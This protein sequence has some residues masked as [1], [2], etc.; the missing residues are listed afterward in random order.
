MTDHGTSAPHTEASLTGCDC[1]SQQLPPALQKHTT[2][3]PSENTP[4]VQ[5]GMTRSNN[6]STSHLAKHNEPYHKKLIWKTTTLPPCKHPHHPS[7]GCDTTCLAPSY[8]RS[9][10]PRQ[11]TVPRQ[12]LLKVHIP[13]TTL[14]L[15]APTLPPHCSTSSSPLHLAPC[16]RIQPA[17]F[18]WWCS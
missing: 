9:L 4:S 6:G 7:R 14:A 10:L 8:E 16:M 11:H 15:A 1:N 12:A 18:L 17:L 5:A 13:P 2:L 3:G